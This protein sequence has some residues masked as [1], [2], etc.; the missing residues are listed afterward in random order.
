MATAFRVTGLDCLVEGFALIRKPG[1]RRYVIVPT[2]INT[3]VLIVLVVISV[4]KFEGWV[5][6]ITNMLP[7]WLSFLSWVIYLVGLIVVAF[8]LFYSFMIV[9]NL[10]ASPF[11]AI[12]SAKIE[13]TLIPGHVHPD[14]NLFFDHRRRCCSRDIESALFVAASRSPDATVCHPVGE[15]VGAVALDFVWWMVAIQYCDYAADNNQV[16]F[17]TLRERMSSHKLSAVSFGIPIN[18]MLAIPLINLFLLPI[19]V[20]GGTVF[21]VRNLRD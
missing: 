14:S 20:A 15:Y 10:I 5:A 8:V 12:L 2:V 1:I 9:A 11:N 18:I 7:D 4:S 21:W 3:L 17:R 16:S 13:E 19:A 6:A